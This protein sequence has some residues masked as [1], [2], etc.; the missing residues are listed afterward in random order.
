MEYF[1]SSVSFH[2]VIFL[3]GAPTHISLSQFSSE[4][5]ILFSLSEVKVIVT[6]VV[7]STRHFRNMFLRFHHTIL[8][9]LK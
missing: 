2:P 7:P 5:F 1:W 6:N 8:L 3:V 4:L 9:G